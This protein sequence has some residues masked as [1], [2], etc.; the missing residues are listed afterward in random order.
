M[1][2]RVLSPLIVTLAACGGAGQPAPASPGDTSSTTPPRIDPPDDAGLDAADAAVHSTSRTLF[3]GNS[4]TYVNDLPGMYRTLAPGAYVD[5]VAYGAY[6]LTYDVADIQGTGASPHLAQLLGPAAPPTTA[7]THVVLQEQ[8]QIAGY[9]DAEPDKKASL[10]AALALSGYVA[11]AH[12]TTVL[13]M[14]W[15]YPNGDPD[16]LGFFPTYLAMQSELEAGYRE[17]AHDVSAAGRA[18]RIAP[19]G[20]AFKAV[21]DREVSAGRDPHAPTSLFMQ[22][23]GP[24]AKHPALPGTFVAACVMAATIDGVDPAALD[25][26]SIAGLDA[27][28]RTLLQTVARDVVATEHARTPP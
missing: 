24:D 12:A 11:A 3:V 17:M 1:R 20:L 4:F 13:Y 23:Y 8:S 28:T 14:T 15:G 25:T 5:S 22:L 10:A 2:L 18:V 21:Y 19:V 7:W 27:P 16:N 6:L 26:G 9:P